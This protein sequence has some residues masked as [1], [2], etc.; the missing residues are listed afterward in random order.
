M[1]CG[2]LFLMSWICPQLPPSLLIFLL[3]CS[4]YVSSPFLLPSRFSSFQFSQWHWVSAEHSRCQT[5]PQARHLDT[6]LAGRGNCLDGAPPYWLQWYGNNTHVFIQTHTPSIFP[7]YIK[8]YI[9]YRRRPI[10]CE[11]EW[12]F[13][14]HKCSMYVYVDKY[15]K[16]Q[17]MHT[18][19]HTHVHTHILT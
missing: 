7:K 11:S 17:Y 15:T 6:A 2:F 10:P 1:I 4:L 18:H 12:F 14:V 13:Y 5:H 19:T 16:Y 8:W 3:P 9:I